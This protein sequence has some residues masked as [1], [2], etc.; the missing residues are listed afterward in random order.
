MAFFASSINRS[1]WALAGLSIIGILYENKKTLAGLFSRR[2][3]VE[4]GNGRDRNVEGFIPAALVCQYPG[5]HQPA[6]RIVKPSEVRATI[7]TSIAYC[8]RTARTGSKT[9][10]ARSCASTTPVTC[11]PTM[12]AN[13]T[14][15][16]AVG[17][18]Q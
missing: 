9:A 13:W 16:M 4:Q 10:S 12:A 11:P 1:A 18:I 2:G 15:Q 5:R 3:C 14:Y 7:K 8:E 6:A 17:D